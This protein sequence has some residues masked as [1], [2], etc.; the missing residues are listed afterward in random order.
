MPKRRRPMGRNGRFFKKKRFH[1]RA[2]RRRGQGHSRTFTKRNITKSW[3]GRGLRGTNSRQ[4]NKQPSMPKKRFDALMSFKSSV[5]TQNPNTVGSGTPNYKYAVQ[6]YFQQVTLGDSILLL[7]HQSFRLNST[8]DPDITG[9]GSQPR[10]RDAMAA[11]YNQ[12]VVIGCKYAI[13][14]HNTGNNEPVYAWVVQSEDSIPATTFDTLKE[15]IEDPLIPVQRLK[16]ANSGTD[17]ESATFTRYVSGKSM[18]Q[19]TTGSTVRQDY[20]VQMSS[21]ISG[22]PSSPSFITVL[23]AQEDGGPVISNSITVTAKLTYYV[24]YYDPLGTLTS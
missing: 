1:G 16:A 7:V 20:A 6:P 3:V 19:P 15:A 22:N 23:V 24:V 12:Y 11:I 2:P 13:Q 5:V 9:V 17:A 10:G 14:V 8:F 18:I 4:T 21:T